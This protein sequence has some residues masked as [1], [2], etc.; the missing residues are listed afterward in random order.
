MPGRRLRTRHIFDLC[1]LTHMDSVGLGAL[2]RVYVSSRKDAA[3]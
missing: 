2:V 1:S 3:S